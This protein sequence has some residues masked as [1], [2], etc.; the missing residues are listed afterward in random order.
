MSN[1]HPSQLP[2]KHMNYSTMLKPLSVFNKKSTI[3]GAITI[4]TLSIVFFDAFIY[5]VL[6]YHGPFSVIATQVKGL[7]DF[8]L[9]QQL[10]DRFQG[11]PPFWR[12]ALYPSFV[13]GWPRLML[14]PNI[15]IL[16]LLCWTIQKLKL[17]PWHLTVCTV[18][19]FPVCLFS[20]RSGYQDFFVGATVSSSLVLLLYSIYHRKLS[21]TILAL[22][23][24]TFSSYTK[25]QGFMQSFLVVIVGYIALLFSHYAS[26]KDHIFNK[27]CLI[28]L[29]FGLLLTSSHSIWNFLIYSNPFYPISV[30]PF[31]GPESNYTA[32]STYT[33]FLYPLQGS[34]NHFL[35]SSELDW[36]FRGV[37]PDYN[38]DMARA[39]TQYGGLLDPKNAMGLVR[40]GGT[41][42]PAYL[43]AFLVFM[44]G[45]LEKLRNLFTVK[46][47]DGHDFLF[48]MT[49]IYVLLASFL[50]QSHELR[51]YLSIFMLISIF[52][53][54]YLCQ[55][56]QIKV[57][58]AALFLFL[59]I[60]CVL[61][62]SQPFYSTAKNGIGYA[63]SYP[64]RDLPTTQDCLSKPDSE[65]PATRFA[66][67]LILR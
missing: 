24:S 61:N 2:L 12:L 16:S 43:A 20:F 59:S 60:S 53:I 31:E 38:I 45:I 54:Y 9:N 65:D 15:L 56:N 23:L 10:L 34:L 67:K 7:S 32:S 13:I 19:V 36:I 4:L 1:I 62:F 27:Q 22:L 25:Y 30:G 47:I 44:Y 21:V 46:S 57:V 66:C 28:L 29:T 11:F 40:T 64:S 8:Q 58:R 55:T 48:L 6:A 33:S 42:G 3:F 35:S 39:Q 51:Y 26:M 17:L 18:F 14:L 49:G 41:Y 5:D 50:P 52:S 37:V 63:V